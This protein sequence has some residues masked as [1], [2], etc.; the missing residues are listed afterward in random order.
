MRIVL[1]DR[2]EKFIDM[3]LEKTDWIIELLI[4]D[5]FS[6]KIK[7]YQNNDRIN[8]V[9]TLSEAIND[10]QDMN[11][12]YDLINKY[13]YAFSLCDYGSRRIRDDYQFSHYEF[14]SGVCYWN[15]FFEEHDIDI[16]LI[17]NHFHGF[18]CDYLLQEVAIGNGIPCFNI[19]YHNFDKLAIYDAKNRRLLPIADD[20]DFHNKKSIEETAYYAQT[21][22]KDA[23]FLQERKWFAKCVYKLGGA[24]LYRILWLLRNGKSDIHYRTCTPMSYLLSYYNIKKTLRNVHKLYKEINAGEKYVIY[25]LHFEPEAVITSF[26]ESVDSQLMYINLLSQSLPEGWTLYVKE[27][28]DTYKLNKWAFE[29]NLPCAYTFLTPYFYQKIAN[30]KNTKLIDYH[31]SAGELIKNS[32]AISTIGGTVAVEAVINKKP[33][34]LFD[35]ERLVYSHCEDFLFVRNK[36][37]CT[38]ALKKID[39]GFIPEYKDFESVQ[40]EYLIDTDENCIDVVIST[41]LQRIN[42]VK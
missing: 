22:D 26:A 2:E 10:D 33:I 15:T 16:C 5:D 30:M 36:K 40:K 13:K 4:V 42:N 34:I 18:R 24:F 29:H 1:S 11:I 3:I 27:H 6:T 20:I 7:E 19:F 32:M 35:K 37:E 31:L 23:N 38:L 9:Q 12:D 41:I 39:E 8:S 28:P 21:F 17:S 25:F 14:F